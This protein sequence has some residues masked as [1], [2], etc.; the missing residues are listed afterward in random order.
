[1]IQSHHQTNTLK[2]KFINKEVKDALENES[3][4]HGRAGSYTS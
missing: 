1:M 3:K 2:V 4:E